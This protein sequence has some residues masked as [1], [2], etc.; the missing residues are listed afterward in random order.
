VLKHSAPFTNGI[1][2]KSKAAAIITATDAIAVL[3]LAG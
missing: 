2:H 1:Q 3:Y